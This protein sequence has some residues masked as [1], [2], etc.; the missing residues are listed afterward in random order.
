[1]G[2]Y[3]INVDEIYCQINYERLILYA[4]KNVN[5]EPVQVK[6]CFAT[7]SNISMFNKTVRKICGV[8]GGYWD[9]SDGNNLLEKEY[10]FGVGDMKFPTQAT[11]VNPIE[12]KFK[13]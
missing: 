10:Y 1:M 2:D 6:I 11:L 8:K 13:F 4:I 3:Q 9:S 5:P 7:P 12:F